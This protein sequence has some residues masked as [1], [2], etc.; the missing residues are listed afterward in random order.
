ETVA[1][2]KNRIEI[3]FAGTLYDG[4]K[5][6]LIEFIKS[7]NK[8][9]IHNNFL[10]VHLTIIG[11]WDRNIINSLKQITTCT[12]LG[13]IEA[14]EVQRVI[15]CSDFTCSYVSPR[16]NYAI[17]TKI[18]ESASHKIPII[19]LSDKGVVSEFISRNNIGIH[20][21]VEN[22]KS[23]GVLRWINGNVKVGPWADLMEHDINYIMR[24]KVLKVID[25]L[26]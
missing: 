1:S 20:I 4:G 7:L 17:N 24:N 22:I 23:D 11:N 12:Y 6:P 8:N 26:L 3:V 18:L 21:D 15:K 13:V 9:L 10:P 14:S 5:A 16:L 19:L 25:S 2:K